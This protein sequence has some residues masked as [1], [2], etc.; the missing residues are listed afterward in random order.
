MAA[1]LSR[2][3]LFKSCAAEGLEA[4]EEAGIAEMALGRRLGRRLAG[5]EF[6][7]AR[8][9]RHNERRRPFDKNGNPKPSF[10][11][12]LQLEREDRAEMRA[13]I[14]RLAEI[15]QRSDRPSAWA[16][17]VLDS[18]TPEERAT[19]GAG[20]HVEPITAPHA[21]V[22]STIDAGAPDD[23]RLL[24]D[25]PR[26]S[27]ANGDADAWE[28]DDE[29]ADDFDAPTAFERLPLPPPTK[30]A[31][32]QRPTTPTPTTNSVSGPRTSGTWR[33]LDDGRVV[34]DFD[35]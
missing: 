30:S 7:I 33:S 28:R 1:Y 17:L 8:L 10:L 19:H 18:F 6:A 20:F 5:T 12:E 35:D 16:S 3:K 13:L 14:D 9:H 22:A 31:A 15:M 32:P 11:L 26:V 27:T 4:V 25:A 34:D 21:S 2:T 23:A 24:L 29:P